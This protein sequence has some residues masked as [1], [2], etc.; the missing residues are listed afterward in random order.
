MLLRNSA[1]GRSWLPIVVI[2]VASWT[3]GVGRVAAQD[4][5]MQY[6]LAAAVD[7]AGT[8]FV[9][10]RNLPGVWKVENDNLAI[11]FQAP[12]KFRTPLN[13]P[14]CAAMDNDGRLLV[15][16]SPT[17]DVYRFGED[18][19]PVG[20]TGGGADGIGIPMDIAVN[21][22]GEILVSDLE[23]QRIAKIPAAGG[24][25]TDF[26]RVPAPTG[27]AIDDKD[28]LWVISRASDPLWR[29]SPDGKAE[30]VVKGRKFQ[31]PA[32]VAVDRDGAVYI[33]DSFAKA[34]WRIP[35][36][37]ES[38]KWVH[39]EPFVHPVG[40]TWNGDDLIVVDTRAPALFKVTKDGQVTKLK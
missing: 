34:I 22:A 2:V 28:Q 3:F 16:C 23:Q 1:S 26:A 29:V 20:L 18:G 33:S 17:R 12:K 4:A 31:F 25:P 13:V 15:G 40:L 10:D 27:L 9:V 21:K 7:G 6:P 30:A 32:D 37:G 11:Y 39:G 36:G 24:K 19:K 35:P 5:E 38:A 8:I 14:R